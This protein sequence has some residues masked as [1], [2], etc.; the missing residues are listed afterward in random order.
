MDPFANRDPSASNF[1]DERFQR[2][3]T[4]WDQ[5]GVPQALQAFVQESAR[6]LVTLIPGCGSAHEAAYLAEAGWDVTA[7]DFSAAAVT[8]AK[9]SLGP[10]ADR[11]LQAD[12]FSYQP[13]HALDLI[14]ERAFL[15][16][17]PPRMRADIAARWAA[18]LPAGGLLA[19]Y[20]FFDNSTK[21]PP[22][23]ISEQELDDLLNPGF[24]LL[25]DAPV[26][27]SISVFQG[28]ERW[29]VWRRR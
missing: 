28:K 3:Y 24:E 9:A 16:A 25:Q 27:D 7:I 14:Y 13:P 15:C 12:F 2:A 8:S 6:P 17:L 11:V 19:G 5:G 21:G 29:K 10:W 22:F 18:L 1:W 23:G 26:Q 4:P 20:F